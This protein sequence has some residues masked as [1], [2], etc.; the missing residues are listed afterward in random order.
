M[1]HEPSL[2]ALDPAPQAA[3]AP[4]R[5]WRFGW[6]VLGM[7]AAG[8]GLWALIIYAGATLWDAIA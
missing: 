5:K 7:F 8:L 4:R 3:P 6:T 2:T 1:V